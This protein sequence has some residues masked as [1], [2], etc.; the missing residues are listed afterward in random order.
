VYK[1]E[2]IDGFQFPKEVLIFPPPAF[3]PN[4]RMGWVFGGP[5]G[6]VSQ[7]QQFFY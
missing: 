7:L 6:N 5:S 4:K 3:N 2:K 1:Y